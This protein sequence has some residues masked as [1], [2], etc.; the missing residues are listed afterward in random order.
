ME[1][2]ITLKETFSPYYILWTNQ[3]ALC[4]L[5]LCPKGTHIPE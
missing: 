2:S 1:D 4:S 3:R 5:E